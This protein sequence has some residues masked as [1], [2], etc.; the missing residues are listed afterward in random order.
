MDQASRGEHGNSEC[1]TFSVLVMYGIDQL[2][3]S[4]LVDIHL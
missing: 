4:M 3:Y 2:P 1:W